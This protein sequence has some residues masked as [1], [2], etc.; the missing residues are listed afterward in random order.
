MSRRLTGSSKY[1]IDKYNLDVEAAEHPQKYNN[2]ARAAARAAKEEKQ[3]E[4]HY[5]KTRAR[6]DKEVRK[7]PSKFGVD[8]DEPKEKAIS[9]AV[10]LDDR[11]EEAYNDYLDAKERAAN[12]SADEKTFEHRK[13]LIRLL[14]E[15]W[16]K[17]YYSQVEVR[18]ERIDKFRDRMGERRGRGR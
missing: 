18:D 15:L 17:D 1:E 2:A 5:L 8:P 10:D 4:R 7:R 11:V 12:A 3:A 9:G 13:I 14:G 16:I 6:V